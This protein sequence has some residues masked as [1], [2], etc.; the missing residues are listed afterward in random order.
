[1]RVISFDREP[2]ELTE[3]ERAKADM[4]FKKRKGGKAYFDAKRRY[5]KLQKENG[6]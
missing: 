3:L 4:D 2:R 1:M 5:E 6:R